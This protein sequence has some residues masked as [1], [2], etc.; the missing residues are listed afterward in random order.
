L[1]LLDEIELELDRNPRG[2]FKGDVFVGEGAAVAAGAGNDP[3][4]TGFLDPLLRG[5]VKLLSPA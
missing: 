2:E 4:G 5:E 3:D 1:E